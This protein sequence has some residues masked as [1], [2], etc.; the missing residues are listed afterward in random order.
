MEAT[1]YTGANVDEVVNHLH[2]TACASGA[3]LV[4]SVTGMELAAALIWPWRTSSVTLRPGQ[5]LLVV[6]G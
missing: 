1:L 5:A 2:K 6:A 4:V 3:R